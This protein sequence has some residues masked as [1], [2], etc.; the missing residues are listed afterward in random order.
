[1]VLG[2][3]PEDVKQSLVLQL[4]LLATVTMTSSALVVGLAVLDHRHP[5][6]RALSCS[7]GLSGLLVSAG[8]VVWEPGSHWLVPQLLRAAGYSL[9]IFGVSRAARRLS[10][11]HLGARGS[12]VAAAFASLALIALLPSSLPVSPVV[13]F[14]AAVGFTLVGDWL[15]GS[16]APSVPTSGDNSLRFLALG[17]VLVMLLTGLAWGLAGRH[18]LQHRRCVDAWSDRHGRERAL[19][20]CEVQRLVWLP[21]AD[22]N[23]PPPRLSAQHGPRGVTPAADP[24]PNDSHDPTHPN[25]PAPST[26]ERTDRE[27]SEPLGSDDLAKRRESARKAAGSLGPEDRGLISDLVERAVSDSDPE[28]VRYAMD[29]LAGIVGPEDA[30]LAGPLMDAVEKSRDPAAVAAVLPVLDA[31]GQAGREALPRVRNAYSARAFGDSPITET[32]GQ[33]LAGDSSSSS[34]GW[35]PEE[36]STVADSIASVGPGVVKSVASDLETSGPRAAP[37]LAQALAQLGD[38]GVPALMMG[39]EAGDDQERAAAADALAMLGASASASATGAQPEAFDSPVAARKRGPERFRPLITRPAASVELP[40]AGRARDLTLRDDIV[41]VASWTR[42]LLVAKEEAGGEVVSVG[43]LDTPGIAAGVA[44][45]GDHVV[46]A[47]YNT[48]RVVD[49]SNPARP[50]SHAALGLPGVLLDVEV[51]GEVAYVAAWHGGLHL[52]S[53]DDPARPRLLAS[54]ATGGRASDV[55]VR[56]GRAYVAAG[57]AGCVVVD[58]SRS[59]SPAIVG[60]VDDVGPVR[61]VGVWGD[62]ILLASHASGLWLYD[63]TDPASPTRLGHYSELTGALDVE[64]D[65]PI[66]YV[67]AGR[68]GLWVV[69]FSDHH[70]PRWLATQLTSG[71]TMA[72]KRRGARVYLANDAVGVTILEIAEQVPALATR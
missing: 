16:P 37:L 6:A 4:S 14:G 71:A 12:A 47:D 27:W 25:F 23:D 60:R 55:E 42:G 3:L 39:V 33:S 72:V 69:D 57:D 8:L 10:S 48:L 31:L 54:I 62:R 24:E 56:I 32:A 38:E 19:E 36:G 66:A 1:M 30:G 9:L 15:F 41:Y 28:T 50:R 35:T 49:V 7:L 44:L 68:L 70:A 40:R 59:R 26:A 18:E 65:G 17:G 5:W 22:R 21:I 61:G 63:L 45:A 53:L 64:V 2:E 58:V 52:V 51:V 43:H 29:A 13:I 20:W 34:G 67:S 46:L 11:G